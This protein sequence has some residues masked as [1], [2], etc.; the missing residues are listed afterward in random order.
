MDAAK[1]KFEL[2]LEESLPFFTLPLPLSPTGN[3]FILNR[4]YPFQ[5]RFCQSTINEPPVL[6][7][8]LTLNELDDFDHN[9]Y[10][11]FQTERT[12]ENTVFTPTK[13]P[14]IYVGGNPYESNGMTI[15]DE[16]YYL[17]KRE[18]ILSTPTTDTDVF[19]PDRHSSPAI[20]T[21][22]KVLVNLTVSESNF[23]SYKLDEIKAEKLDR[24]MTTFSLKRFNSFSWTSPFTSRISI[25]TTN[26]TNPDK[27]CKKIS[28]KISDSKPRVRKSKKGQTEKPIDSLMETASYTNTH[29]RSMSGH[30]ENTSHNRDEIKMICNFSLKELLLDASTGINESKITMDKIHLMDI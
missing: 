5:F 22:S 15:D 18:S 17:K 3:C 13:N 2:T 26:Q 6:S 10:M 23:N 25:E 11:P 27:L 30:D 21:E 1:N 20:T 29:S 28:K 4:D 7:Q 12:H 19:T 8:S 24:R 14:Q 16:F 9:A